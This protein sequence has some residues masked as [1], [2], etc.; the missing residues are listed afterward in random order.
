MQDDELCVV[1][2][3][4]FE[5]TTLDKRCV[6]PEISVVDWDISAI[7]KSEF[8]HFMLKEIF[9]QPVTIENAF[10]GRIH[11]QLGTARLGGLGIPSL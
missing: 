5:I 4:G 10:R 2:A 1:K 8:K 3:N 11:Q 6:K 9:E 7:E